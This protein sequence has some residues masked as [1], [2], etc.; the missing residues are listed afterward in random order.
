MT[1]S[2]YSLPVRETFKT[3]WAKVSGVKGSFWAV[4]GIFILAQIV[5][6]FLGGLGGKGG[7]INFIFSLV[8]S[9]IQIVA[10]AC[11]VYLGIRRAQDVPI[12]YKS[13]KEVLNGRII[14]YII[15]LYIL[16]L[17]IFIP[18]A[19]LAGIGVGLI[20]LSAEPSTFL[21]IIAII[22]YIASVI[23]FVF[24][25]VR[26]WLGYGAVVDKNVNPWEAIKLSFKATDG[27]VWNLIGIYI[28]SILIMLVC[29]ITFG[30]GFIWGLPWLL[31]TYGETY[32]RLSTR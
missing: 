11:L 28:L 23:L 8:G 27:N 10:G 29:A 25:S 2:T 21:D 20:H 14:L 5:V 15:G 9:L 32:K 26:M 19:I 16:Q 31:I 4:V 17:V 18:A 12:S 13:A 30:I 3:A 6:G 22:F 7:V 1:N 24:L